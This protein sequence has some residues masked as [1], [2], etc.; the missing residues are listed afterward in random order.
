MVRRPPRSSPRSRR[1]RPPP[2]SPSCQLPRRLATGGVDRGRRDDGWRRNHDRRRGRWLLPRADRKQLLAD[3]EHDRRGH[4][5]DRQTGAAGDPRIRRARTRRRP[6]QKLGA[7]AICPRDGSFRVTQTT[8]S[9]SAMS[10][11]QKTRLV[12]GSQDVRL[13]LGEPLDDGAL[14]PW[15]PVRPE[16]LPSL[17]REVHASL[18]IATALPQGAREGEPRFRHDVLVQPR[19]FT[20]AQCLLQDWDG[21]GGAPCASRALPMPLQA[22]MRSSNP[23][24]RDRRGRPASRSRTPPPPP[25]LCPGPPG[26]RLWCC[27]LEQGIGIRVAVLAMD[28]ER[29]V[30]HLQ[31]FSGPSILLEDAGEALQG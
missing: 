30:R 12:P 25:T 11:D 14:S 8:S 16:G 17:V 2:S 6:G 23:R 7:D 19:A 15:K 20:N 9:L 21:C 22:E 24:V 29:S 1:R 5:R 31:R 26:L 28:V 10:P 4:A 27:A 13:V 3:H 18:A